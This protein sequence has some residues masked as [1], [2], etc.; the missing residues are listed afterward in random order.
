[1]MRLIL[2]TRNCVLSALSHPVK[3]D[4]YSSLTAAWSPHFQH[5][6]LK[7]LWKLNRE[8]RSSCKDASF[9]ISLILSWLVRNWAIFTFPWNLERLW[10]RAKRHN[11]SDICVPASYIASKQLMLRMKVSIVL[12]NWEAVNKINGTFY[13]RIQE[14]HPIWISLYLVKYPTPITLFVAPR[15]YV[16]YIF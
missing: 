16:G 7:L 14:S 13:S 6:F 8:R 9:R 1:M 10:A 11:L 2:C 4:N 5:H 12:Y 15:W 3:S